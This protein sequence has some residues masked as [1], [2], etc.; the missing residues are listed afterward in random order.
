MVCRAS[1]IV[2]AARTP[3]FEARLKRGNRLSIGS[4]FVR[5]EAISIAQY[6]GCIERSVDVSS[7]RI[8]YALPESSLV[9][10]SV[11]GEFISRNREGG[12]F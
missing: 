4:G 5:L 1:Y 7:R 12:R 6:Q 8:Q 11:S 3:D 10:Y 2:C 9:P